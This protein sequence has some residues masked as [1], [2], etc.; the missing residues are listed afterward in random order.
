[1]QTFT[2]FVEAQQATLGSLY[3]DLVAQY[4]GQE[5]R[6]RGILKD[7][8]PKA[9]RNYGRGGISPEHQAYMKKVGA[10]I[11]P[12]ILRGPELTPIQ[13]FQYNYLKDKVAQVIGGTYQPSS[14]QPTPQP[15]QQQRRN[16]VNN[17]GFI[18]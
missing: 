5:E 3:N 2:Q 15:Q 13:P 12:R 18:D 14:R 6:I 17:N 11:D 7:F 8:A 1:M 9:V 4:P 16:L 10:E